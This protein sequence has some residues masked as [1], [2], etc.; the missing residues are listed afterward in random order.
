MPFTAE[1]NLGSRASADRAPKWGRVRRRRGAWVVA[2][3][4]TLAACAGLAA[5]PQ[6]TGSGRN[7]PG[8]SFA[9][10]NVVFVTASNGAIGT[11]G[12]EFAEVARERGVLHIWP[13]QPRPMRSLESFGCGCAAFDYDNDGRQDV[14]L[15]ADP[16]PLLYRN[17]GGGN[18]VNMTAESGLH[19][20][21]AAA[22]D[23]DRPRKRRRHLR[24][25]RAV[26]TGVA[27]G[28]YDGDGWLDV[29]LTGFHRLA[30]LRNDGGEAFI[31][32]T[33]QAGLDPANHGR[34]G[35][36]A[37]FMDLD[38]DSRLDLVI[39]NLVAFG[40]HSKQYC[41]LAP[42]VVSGCPPNEYPAEKGEIW[43]NV[44]Q[45]A[46]EL[47]PEAFAMN[48]SSGVALVLA[49][50]D[51]DD[52][53]R[54]DF[55]IGN[56]GMPADFM[57]SLG[58]MR[59]KN[60]GIEIGICV[61]H[62]W[63]PMS[64]MGA[65]WADYD[66]DGLLDLTVTD[67]Q[68]KCFAL[69]RHEAHAQRDGS[70][71]HSFA[72]VGNQS[73]ISSATYDRLGFGAKWLDMDNDGWPDV[74]YTN[75]HVYDNAG[76]IKVGETFRQ[77]PTWLRN[78]QGCRF[79]DLMPALDPELAR[80]IVGRGSAT[81]DFDNDGRV[82]VLMVDFEG[83]PRLFEN[84]SLTENH[85]VKFDLRGAGSNTFA[86]GARVTAHVRGGTWVGEVSPASSYLSASDPRIHFGLGR[87][88]SLESVT[89]RWPS[90]RVEELRHVP[91][92]QIVRVVEQRG[93][94]APP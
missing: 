27:V 78:E 26:W 16:C 38:G 36:S 7:S 29:L 51:F 23:A 84:R 75:G 71:S 72:E 62:G 28:D 56:D 17:T 49:F 6:L 87:L 48:D 30:L 10:A 86:Y 69:F 74:C 44:G 39:L 58:G 91:A 5:S 15:V 2:G 88:T 85:W 41:E 61:G 93:I 20:A 54:Q 73:G 83:A 25:H 35:T 53:N 40:P 43:R 42:G 24:Q 60:I 76:D 59:F 67:F 1:P 33:Q 34:W 12:V 50:S 55:Y 13:R 82:D 37:G 4:F 70:R 89:I 22:G 8:P 47:V 79:V 18:F 66:R 80:P 31:D 90:G 9:A 32:V 65:D 77:A 19:S 45:S 21:Q 14:L 94:V 3:G 92:D 64:A 57:H 11:G 68:K 46:F 81:A 52:D 63:I